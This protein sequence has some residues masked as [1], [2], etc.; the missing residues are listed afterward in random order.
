MI[1]ALDKAGRRE[2]IIPL[3]EHEAPITLSYGRLLDHLMEASRWDAARSW[4]LR[5]IAACPSRYLGIS[6][7]L[8]RRMRAID[9]RTGNR[10]GALAMQAEEFFASP[11]VDGFQ[12]LCRAA[13]RARVG[14]AVETWARCYL[15]SGR[16]PTPD[17]AEARRKRQGEPSVDWPLPVSA[18]A[19]ESGRRIPEAPMLEPLIQIAIADKNPDEVLKWYDRARRGRQ[20]TLYS[21]LAAEVAEAV[22]RKHPERAL[23][24]WKGIAE[25]HIATVQVTGYEAAAPYLRK[26][27]DT[28]TRSR[29]TKLWEAYL[30][31]LRQ[32]NK[33][34][35]R[36]LQVL[37]RVAGMR[38]RIVDT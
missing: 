16:R 15:E 35:P 25:R 9:E 21:G 6:S 11:D 36:C 4:C 3:C 32:Q 18:A 5:G 8:R 22:R 14:K 30:E 26:V 7:D 13:R 12:E 31:S 34:R 27:K 33:R 23:E 38:R 2:E 20:Y 10:L 17:G 24:I 1:V 29:K 19:V 37:D 28:L